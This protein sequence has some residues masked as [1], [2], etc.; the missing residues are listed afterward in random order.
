MNPTVRKLLR[1]N[2]IQKAKSRLGVL[3]RERNR[4]ARL[5]RG[6]WKR[7]GTYLITVDAAPDGRHIA[8]TVRSGKPERFLCGSERTVTAAL[9]RIIWSKPT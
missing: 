4:M 7:A 3:A 2:D 9:R 5:D 8:L 1:R 6:P